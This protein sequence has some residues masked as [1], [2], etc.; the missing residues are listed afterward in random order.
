MIWGKADLTMILNG[1]L[2]GLVAITADPLSPSL[3]MAGVIGVVA[4]GLVVFSIVGLTESRSTTQ[5]ARFL[6]TV[7]RV[8]SV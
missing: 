8:S 1:I 3:L 6:C 2:A 5:W 7:L 4:G